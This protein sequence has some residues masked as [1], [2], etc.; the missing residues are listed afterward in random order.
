ME[1]DKN[2]LIAFILNFAFS[3]FE[4]IGGFFT[5]SVAIASDAI[6]DMGDA[7][8]IGIS[9]FLE[10]QSRK[11]ATERYTYGFGACSVIGS[12]VTTVILIVGS[13]MVISNAVTRLFVPERIYYDGMIIFAVIGVVVNSFA[14]FFTRSGESLNQKAVNLHMLEDVLAWIAVLIGAFIMRFTDFAFIDPLLSIAVAVFILVNAVR[15]FKFS[16]DIFLEKVPDGIEVSGIK[17]HLEEIDGV[18]EVHHIHI[19]SI[20]GRTNCA[21][22]HIVSDGDTEAL[23][24]KI[25]CELGHHGIEHVTLEFE[26]PENGCGEVHCAAL[27][28]NAPHRHRHHHHHH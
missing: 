4:F 16:V 21:T 17:Q 9:Y 28:N 2:I 14:A 12:V 18:I 3:I 10:K 8:S 23:K 24:K 11:K 27:E 25:R 5:G 7:L 15:N 19:R 20:D 1:S 22:M 13:F 26:T 6:H